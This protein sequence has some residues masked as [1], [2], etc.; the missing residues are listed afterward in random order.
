MPP[1]SSRSLR[2][3]CHYEVLSLYRISTAAASVLHSPTPSHAQLPRH[4]D[5]LWR[6]SALLVPA[7]ITHTRSARC[8]LS[9]GSHPASFLAAQRL[10][11]RQHMRQ[12]LLS[13]SEQQL[14]RTPPCCFLTHPKFRQLFRF[15]R[16]RYFLFHKTWLPPLA[17]IL[18][19]VVG[20]PCTRAPTA[21]IQ[22]CHAAL[23][24]LPPNAVS[25]RS[26]WRADWFVSHVCRSVHCS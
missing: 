12:D 3:S 5:S 4:S 21:C 1:S 20:L 14:S 17:H 11:L 26:L 9:R 18:A 23:F 19:I 25:S 22:S 8:S 15:A 2:I 7:T 10:P 6:P 16:L 13:R 24:V